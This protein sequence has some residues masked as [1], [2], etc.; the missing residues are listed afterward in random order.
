[1]IAAYKEGIPDH[2]KP[3]PDGVKIV[4]I[5]WIKKKNPLSPYFVE[6]PDTLRSV[7]FIVKD[8]KRFPNPH[9][10]A[11]AEFAYDTQSKTFKVFRDRLRMRICVPHESG[12]EGLHLRR[13][14]AQVSTVRGLANNTGN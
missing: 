2:G 10:W 12:L 4:K 7:D 11:Y 5:E 6:V 1:M 13:V 9:G 14:S 3:F 8:S